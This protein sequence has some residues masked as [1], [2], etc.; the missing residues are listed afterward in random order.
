MLIE[1][2]KNLTILIVDKTGSITTHT[3]KDYKEEDLYKKCGFT[4]SDGFNKQTEWSKKIDGSKYLITVYGKTI[5]NANH[6]NKYEFPPPID[7]H[8]FFGKCALIGRKILSSGEQE[9]ISLNIVLWN[10]I[11]EKLMGGFEDLSA[12]AKEDEDEEDELD[13][14]P[15]SK[16]TKSGYL[17]DGFV[18]DDTD[19]D[20]ISSDSESINDIVEENDTEDEP[21]EL[22]VIPKKHR[23]KRKCS[24]EIVVPSSTEKYD[25]YVDISIELKEEAFSDDDEDNL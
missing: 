20:N 19:S 14:I 4:K 15:D 21:E 2:M 6:E 12:T 3:I 8:L 9:F 11:Y 24:N 22:E 23:P 5:G 25:I 10:N 13:M 17:K 1:P 16:K 18:I 7:K